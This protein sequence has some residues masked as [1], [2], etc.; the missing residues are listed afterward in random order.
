[1]SEDRKEEAKQYFNLTLNSMITE[2]GIGIGHWLISELEKCREESKKLNIET[3]NAKDACS[4]KG[5]C[6]KAALN[7]LSIARAEV[8]HLSIA[9]GGVGERF[10]YQRRHRKFALHELYMMRSV[11]DQCDE[12]CKYHYEQ[13]EKFKKIIQI[14]EDNNAMLEMQLAQAEAEVEKCR[15]EVKRLKAM[16]AIGHFVIRE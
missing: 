10:E 4:A 2:Y 11:A 14:E 16:L 13:S 12:D 6:M 15:A 5:A 7:Q 3:E 8:D 1:M 9:I